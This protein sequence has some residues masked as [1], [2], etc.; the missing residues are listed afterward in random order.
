MPDDA[1]ADIVAKMAEECSTTYKVADN[2][3]IDWCPCC[4]INIRLRLNGEIFAKF[5][6]S[7]AISKQI[8]AK[9]LTTAYRAEEI[10]SD[11]A[12]LQKAVDD[13]LGACR[14]GLR[15]TGSPEVAK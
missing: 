13:V 8:G 6:C 9:L 10:Q 12:V 1:I 5:I 14:K 7:P 3:E 2:A 4:G 11:P 15:R